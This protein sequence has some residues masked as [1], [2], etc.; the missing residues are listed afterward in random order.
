MPDHLD[1]REG[2]VLAGVAV[3]PVEVP[4]GGHAVPATAS[5]LAA[6]PD[7]HGGAAV[8]HDIPTAALY[9]LTERGVWAVACQPI[10]QALID[11]VRD[12]ERGQ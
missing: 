6:G 8:F 2:V 5:L 11:L 4:G 1:L 12:Q 7:E 9:V 10:W 3:L